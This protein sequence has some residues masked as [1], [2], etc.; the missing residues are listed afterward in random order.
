MLSELCILSI[1]QPILDDHRLLIHCKCHTW[2]LCHRRLS[3]CCADQDM[4][5]KIFLSFAR[6]K[7]I[8]GFCTPL[9]FKAQKLPSRAD[10][11][12]GSDQW[13]TGEP[14]WNERGA[15]GQGE[16]SRP[17]N[18]SPSLYNTGGTRWQDSK[19][20]CAPQI[21]PWLAIKT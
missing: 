12:D 17:N 16:G 19:S 14:K 20:T 9:S 1:L 6:F 13:K 2:H 5:H 7:S 18:Q 10:C 11:T 3:S 4:K 8:E 21:K 15:E